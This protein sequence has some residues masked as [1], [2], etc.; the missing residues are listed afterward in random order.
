GFSLA[1]GRLRL[2]LRGDG[3]SARSRTARRA[4]AGA[5][6]LAFALALPIPRPRWPAL[7]RVGAD[8]HVAAEHRALVDHQLVGPQVA[9]V[10]GGLF[11]L[12]AVVGGEVAVHLAFHHDA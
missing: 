11:Q 12:D 3:L 7:D 4:R 6:P 8:G 10:A 5:G 9:L 2:G 1:P